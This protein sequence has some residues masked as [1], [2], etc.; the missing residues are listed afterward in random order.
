MIVA[1]AGPGSRLRSALPKLLV[2]VNGRSLLEW[3]LELY[4][5]HVDHVVLV[6]NPSAEAQ[7]RASGDRTG[8]ALTYA[9]Q[10]S[11]TGM[12]DAIL[13][14]ADPIQAM[15][16]RRVWV[17]WCDQVAIHPRTVKQLADL[18]EKHAG[19]A[20]VLPTAVRADPYI[21]FVRDEAGRIV[22]VLQRREG[23]L[24]PPRGESDA[25]LFSL[26]REAYLEQLPVFASEAV[27]GPSTGERNF[28]P[29]IPW[30]AQRAEVLAFACVDDME[31][32]GINTPEDLASV[33]DYLAS[34]GQAS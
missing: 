26:S 21:H 22:R 10:R 33:A 34:R 7:V 13:A 16:A 24:M 31:A 27:A 32:V 29:F 15:D 3:L 23:D 9:I 2:P 5:P 18:S 30:I 8:A 25:G 28:L 19:T 17:T 20:L 12:L 6:V 1:V 11:P 4:R 14:A